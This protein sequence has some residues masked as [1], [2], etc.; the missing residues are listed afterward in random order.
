MNLKSIILI[1]FAEAKPHSKNRCSVN[2]IY[3][4][5]IT[6]FIDKAIEAKFQIFFLYSVDRSKL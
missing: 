6:T 3:H 1:I 5:E 4:I 2:I